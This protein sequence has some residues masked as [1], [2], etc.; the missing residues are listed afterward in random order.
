MLKPATGAD[1]RHARCLTAKREHRIPGDDDS[2]IAQVAARLAVFALTALVPVAGCGGGDGNEL[3]ADSGTL[4]ET[5]RSEPPSDAWDL[6]ASTPAQAEVAA[7]AVWRG[8]GPTGLLPS[9][10][11]VHPGV[12]GA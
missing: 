11:S 10:R 1:A 9:A 4:K 3:A 8:R 7:S 12:P 5:T 2:P 6:V